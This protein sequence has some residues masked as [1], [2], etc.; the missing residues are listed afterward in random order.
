LAGLEIEAWLEVGWAK[1]VAV[2][3]ALTALVACGFSDAHF[4]LCSDNKGVCGAMDA[5]HSRNV[6]QTE[7]LRHTVHLFCE[8]E[9]DIW[10][11]MLWVLTKDNVTDGPSRRRLLYNFD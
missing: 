8:H 1:M 3:L 4:V 11:T 7:I 5:G 2:E 6:S 10:F 9:H